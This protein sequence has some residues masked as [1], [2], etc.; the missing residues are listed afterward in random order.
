M[1]KPTIGIDIGGT[2]IRV[3]L[4]DEHGNVI[5]RRKTISEAKKGIDFVLKNLIRL[6]DEIQEYNSISGIGIGVAGIIDTKEGILTEAPN[7]ANVKDY[8]FKKNLLD[9]LSPGIPVYI[10]N[11]ANCATVGE[12]WV[13]AGKGVDS[14]V[15]LTLGTGVGGGIIL[16]GRLWSGADGMAG[17]IG[18]MTIYPDGA[19]CNCGN[20]GCLESY[21]SAEAIRGMVKEG[22]ENKNVNTFLKDEIV[23][24]SDNN[25]PEI[26]MRAAK[27][28]DRYSLSIWERVG[29]ALGITVANLAN[30]LNIEM[31]ILGGGISNSWDL[32]IDRLL[33]VS[34]QRALKYPIK[35]IKVRKGVLGDDAGIIGAGYMAF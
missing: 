3:A 13:G 16:D 28:G 25:I 1:K 31:I 10:D 6:I 9:K 14:M 35:R 26:V 5:L 19:R 18:H 27:R 2:N 21:A 17:E 22:L 4:I 12:W 30:I 33:S 20:Y 15:A 8:A 7:I 32:F 29:E 24:V 34:K 11:D 23:G